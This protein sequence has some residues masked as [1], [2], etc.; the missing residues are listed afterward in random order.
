MKIAKTKG[1]IPI[2]LVLLGASK[3]YGKTTNIYI[4]E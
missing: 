4:L 3:N 2:E 1:K